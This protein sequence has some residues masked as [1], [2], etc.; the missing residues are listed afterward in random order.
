MANDWASSDAWDQAAQR[1]FDARIRRARRRG[2][3]YAEKARVLFFAKPVSP[4]DPR[5]RAALALLERGLGDTTD[6]SAWISSTRSRVVVGE[7]RI[8]PFSAAIDALEHELPLV[9]VLDRL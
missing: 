4:E 5:R 6:R 7:R 1:D 8:D 2:R 9:D 3:F